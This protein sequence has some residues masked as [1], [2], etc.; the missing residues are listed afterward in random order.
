M[1]DERFVVCCVIKT[2]NELEYNFFGRVSLLQVATVTGINTNWFEKFQSFELW[3]VFF[4]GIFP[5]ES[6]IVSSYWEVRETESSRNRDS[7]VN[8]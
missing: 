7:T 1:R 4:P 3:R 2:Q 5:R 8:I 6:R